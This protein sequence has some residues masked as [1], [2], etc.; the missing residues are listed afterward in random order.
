[1]RKRTV[2]ALSTIFM[3]LGAL[4]A[5]CTSPASEGPSPET[6]VYANLNAGIAFWTDRTLA[7]PADF[8]AANKLGNLYYQRARLTSDIADYERA[9]AAYQSA[10]EA[11][12]GTYIDGMLG[13]GFVATAR[14]DFELAI[15]IAEA[16]L[17]ADPG[18]EAALAIR[19]DAL[20]ALGRYDEA[21]EDYGALTERAPGLASNARMAILQ[22]MLGDEAA[23]R[24][25]WTAALADTNAGTTDRAWALAEHGNF[26]FAIGRLEDARASHAAALELV[27]DYLPAQL[28]LADVRAAEGDLERAIAAYELAVRRAPAPETARKLGDLLTAAG[29]SDGA[30]EQY[31]LIDAFAELFEAQGI[32]TELP[33]I[34]YYADHGRVAEAVAMARELYDLRPGIYSADALA[35][36]LHMWGKDDEAAPFAEEAVRYGTLDSSLL[37]RAGVVLEAAGDRERARGLVARALELNPHFST[38]HAGEAQALL[39]RLN[40]RVEVAK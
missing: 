38:L 27:R 12:P 17:A 31:A 29:R 21:L 14:H 2:L 40:T 18:E 1:M 33:V 13:L 9:G 28:G 11:H 26:L 23:A 24:A 36:A 32:R 5:S 30:A 25:S 8:V 6:S 16:A 20:V 35:W 3:A 4:L 19:G 7:D 22:A 15:T 39:A 34:H 37:Y 10:V